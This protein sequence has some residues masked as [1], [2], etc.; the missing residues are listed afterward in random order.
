[1]RVGLGQRAGDPPQPRGEHHRPGDV[2][3]AAEH[4][5]GAAAARGCGGTRRGAATRLRERAQRARRWAAA[6]AR[7]TRERVER[8]A[9]LRNEPRLDAIRRPGERHFHVRARAAL[10]PLRATARRD[11][12][13]PPA[14]IRHR[15]C[16]CSAIAT[17]DVKEDADRQERDDEARAAVR[18]ERQRNP[19]QRR[20]PEDGG[21]VDRRLPAD[22]RRDARREPLSERILAAR[23]A[24]RSPA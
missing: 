8:V 6:G 20:E 10:P 13:F 11:R 15:S 7:E 23:C 21:E 1:M 17:G 12:P 5:V 14:A 18:D 4:D 9:A 16:R 22:E 19:G 24:S 2:A 3:A